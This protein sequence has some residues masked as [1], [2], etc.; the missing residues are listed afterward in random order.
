MYLKNLD[1]IGFKSFANRIKLNFEPGI[2]AI[3]G[4]NGCGKTNI[5]DS[6]RWVLGEQS[7]KSL[8]GS[9]MEDVIFHGTDNRKGI[10]M[11]EVSLTID[12][13]QKILP[14]DYSEVTV[15]R[16]VFRSGESQ[17]FLNK[18]LCR[19]RDIDNLFMDTGVG[20]RAYSVLEQGKMDL[21]LSSKPEDRR[22]VFEE[23]AG[24]TK[25]K[26]R[27]KEALHKLEITENNLVRLNDIVKEVGRQIGAMERKAAKARRY[28][29]IQEEL[30]LLESKQLVI[31]LK[32]LELEKKDY[33]GQ[34]IDTQKQAEEM[35]N[36]I[37]ENEK[38]LV[39]IKSELNR[40]RET[41]SSLHE[42][43][44]QVETQLASKRQQL[45]NSKERIE[46]LRNRN[47]KI[48]ADILK[49]DQDKE[50]VRNQAATV[51][52]EIAE[53]SENR[54]QRKEVLGQKQ[55][56]VNAINGQAQK[57]N[58]VIEA[59]REELLTITAQGSQIKNELSRVDME[60]KDIVLNERRD[61]VEL[62]KKRREIEKLERKITETEGILKSQRN[63]LFELRHVIKDR[64]EKIVLLRDE[65]ASLQTELYRLQQFFSEKR[66]LYEIYSNQKKSLEGYT[67]G[68]RKALENK[69]DF[70]DV[71]GVVADLIKV[72]V[73][74][75]L[76]FNSILGNKAQWLVV[77]TF[78]NA[79]NAAGIINKDLVSQ[80][81]FIVAD[82]LGAPATIAKDSLI[83]AE[84]TFALDII[85]CDDR[86]NNLAKYLLGNVVIVNDI[87]TAETI[88]AETS[89]T[90]VTK[91][92]I[93][94]NSHGYVKGGKGVIGAINLIDRESAINELKIILSD[95]SEKLLQ[96]NQKQKLI[97]DKLK[98]EE[99]QMEGARNNL[100]R[101]EISLAVQEN[102]LIKYRTIQKQLTEEVETVTLELK[103]M[104]KHKDGVKSKQEDSNKDIASNEDKLN[105][106]D[107]EL[108]NLSQEM[109]SKDA[110]RNRLEREYTELKIILVSAE[111]KENHLEFKKQQLNNQLKLTH[112][113]IERIKEEHNSNE[114]A[115]EELLSRVNEME[116]SIID[117][118]NQGQEIG[119]KVSENRSDTENM[120][121]ALREKEEA[122]RLERD[123]KDKISSQLNE[124]QLR[125]AEL[126][127]KIDDI[128]KKLEDRYR[129]SLEN[130]NEIVTDDVS[131][132]NLE[133][134]VITLRDKLESMGEVSLVAIE[135]YEEMQER[136]QFLSTQKDDL[137]NSKDTLLKAIA[138]VNKTT[139]KIFWDTFQEIR[140][141]FQQLF[142][143]LFGGGK[144]DLILLDEADVLESG[145]EIIARP[146]GKKLQNVS[147][148]SGG[149]K[150]LTAIA[151]L[152]S[153]FKVKP[154]P[155][156]ILDEIDAPLDDSNIDRFTSLLDEFSQNTQF[157]VVTH[158]KRT[159]SA[160]GVLYGVTME[161][162]GISKVVSV[163]FEKKEPELQ[164]TQV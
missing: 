123:R 25:Y 86:Y 17:Y 28:K 45:T 79:F 15:T 129:L 74:Y 56:E 40:L 13:T 32:N 131:R 101:E 24:I 119:G 53:A 115:N 89:V 97:E 116:T 42:E 65:A 48:E 90:A 69:N 85:K 57:L 113:T 162:S 34:K 132:E 67:D 33:E 147:L 44:L 122:V 114:L 72:P 43:K 93:V 59:K 142:T 26:E 77:P 130:I 157:M 75:S 37:Q 137:V 164:K 16:R 4:P 128:M 8:R 80:T 83:G 156:C 71:C 163:K 96:L 78:A 76:A 60:F 55:E 153:M 9:R 12:N 110:E 35:Y 70:P 23:A 41:N 121:D 87:K 64:E 100:Y 2:I 155:F 84:Y 61:I 139:K 149:E 39:D 126:Q 46:E 6:V 120:E 49:L 14:I 150:A 111:E 98:Q 52:Q 11:A 38:T 30:K 73:E 1:I 104:S 117:L 145:I 109:S 31:Q 107:S 133:Q 27:K 82:E 148:L 95:N 161:E 92:G 151:L 136:H 125:L 118:S 152:F 138:Q 108:K 54:L 159:I 94:V 21:I 154:S 140:N 20:T 91:D 50:Q 29:K 63:S 134:E 62:N 127:L 5:V 7:A 135:E 18:N 103:E 10:G 124:R 102:D 106:L 105:F 112:E 143:R 58:S 36:L 66:S 51:N 144:A 68:V 141:N 88:C 19:L 22:F 99:G 81:T 160:A 146:P 158:S 47:E 3:V